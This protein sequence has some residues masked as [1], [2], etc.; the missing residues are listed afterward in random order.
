MYLLTLLLRFTEQ[1]KN[2]HPPSLHQS[3]FGDN[4]YYYLKYQPRLIRHHK[5]HC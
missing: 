4:F 2:T 5:E 1:A 3:F